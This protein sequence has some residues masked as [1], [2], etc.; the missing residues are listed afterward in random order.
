M[1]E[2]DILMGDSSFDP[3]RWDHWLLVAIYIGLSGWILWRVYFSKY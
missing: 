1:S 2:T 3:Q